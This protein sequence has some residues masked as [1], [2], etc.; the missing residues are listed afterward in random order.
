ME[1][2]DMEA[3]VRMM[4]LE[5]MP[6]GSWRNDFLTI[7]HVDGQ[8]RVMVSGHLVDDCDECKR[9]EQE[10]REQQRLN[11]CPCCGTI[12]GDDEDDE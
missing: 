8:A 11:I 12:L 4:G 2:L 3:V 9:K 7:R 1:A 5:V 6:D 10:E